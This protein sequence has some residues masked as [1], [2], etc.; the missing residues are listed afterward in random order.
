MGERL[1]WKRIENTN[2]YKPLFDILKLKR[3]IIYFGPSLLR[4]F[5]RPVGLYTD[6]WQWTK[7]IDTKTYY[8][9]N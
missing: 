7:T 5:V 6:Q 4:V 8:T 1:G 9:G 3:T 2:I